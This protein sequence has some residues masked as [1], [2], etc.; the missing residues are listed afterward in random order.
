MLFEIRN[1]KGEHASALIAVYIVCIGIVW[2]V[3]GFLK[4]LREFGSSSYLHDI[5]FLI[6]LVLLEISIQENPEKEKTEEIYNA[7]SLPSENIRNSE[8]F[9]MKSSEFGAFYYILN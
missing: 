4:Q 3:G 9:T 8:F 7:E 5:S 6:Q 1:G 2:T